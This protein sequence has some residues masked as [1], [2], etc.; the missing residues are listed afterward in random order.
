VRCDVVDSDD[1]DDVSCVEVTDVFFSV[2]A[3]DLAVPGEV[4]KLDPVNAERRVSNIV[5]GETTSG[6]RIRGTFVARALVCR[7]GW[8]CARVTWLTLGGRR[9]RCESRREDDNYCGDLCFARP[10]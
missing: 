8:L 10:R 2:S 5:G 4:R 7:G 6:G 1:R 3:A 9:A